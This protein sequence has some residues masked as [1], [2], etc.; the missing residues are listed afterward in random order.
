MSKALDG[1]RVVDLTQFEAGTSA[2]QI[3]ALLGADVIKVENPEGGDPGRYLGL[4]MEAQHG[5]DSNYFLT[6]NS[7]KRSVTLDLK[8]EDGRRQALALVKHADVVAEN[9]APGVLERLGLSY[10]ALQAANPRI[11]LARIKGFGTYGPYAGFKSFDPVAQAMG[12]S[13]CATGAAGGPP[14]RPGVTVGDSGTGLHLVIGILA[15]LLQR[16]ATGAGQQVEVSMMDAVMNL[17]RVWMRDYFETGVS[18]PRAG[19]GP[20]T[21]PATNI[22]PCAPGGPDDYVYVICSGTSTRQIAALLRELGLT[23]LAADPRISDQAF[24]AGHAQEIDA[25]LTAWTRERSKYEAMHA[26]ARIGVPAGPCLNAADLYRDP[27]VQ[28][29]EMVV[30][31]H[32]PVRGDVRLPG[33]PIK[34]SASPAEFRPAPLLGQH[35][36][37]VLAALPTPQG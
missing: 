3:L 13:F 15:A 8:S 34:L 35:T 6:L 19:S 17:S 33:F 5:R 26:L 30:A 22:F 27:H 9:M 12:G 10:A 25:T 31:M 2:T 16:N 37:E 14:M 11:I 29:R 23:A 7:N 20:T 28:A 4:G 36:S 24:L 1:V 18:P 32:H 21:R